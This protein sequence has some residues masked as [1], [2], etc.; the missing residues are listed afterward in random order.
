M[1]GMRA[2]DFEG[3]RITH[4]ERVA[5]VGQLTDHNVMAWFGA[6]LGAMWFT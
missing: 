6:M 5:M 3:P 4:V 2:G 1:M